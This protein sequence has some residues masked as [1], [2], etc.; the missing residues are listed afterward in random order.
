MTRT[1]VGSIFLPRDHRL[2][3]E[4]LAIGTSLHI[5][6]DTGLKVDVER[7]WDVLA[8]A[9]LREKGRKPAVVVLL[10][11]TQTTVRLVVTLMS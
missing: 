4:Q 2:W 8:T 9:S 5:I 11:L 7:P 1:V 10:A 3:V 6:D